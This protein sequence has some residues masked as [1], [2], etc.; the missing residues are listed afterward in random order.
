MLYNYNHKPLVCMQT[1]ST[2]YNETT[3]MT[4]KGVLWHSTGC[5]NPELRRYVQPSE[6]T[7]TEDSFSRALWLEILGKNVNGNDWNHINHRAGL[8]CWIG[9]LANGSITTVQTMPWNYAPWGCG[10]GI[11][12]SC[13]NG[14]IQFEICEPYSLSDRAY[15]NAVYKEACELTAYLC[16]MYNIDPLGIATHSSGIKVPTILCHKDSNDYG[17][18]GNHGDIMHW[19]P[20]HGKTMNDVRADVAALLRGA[21]FQLA[22][23]NGVI[24]NKPSTGSSGATLPETYTPTGLATQVVTI[25]P[26]EPI[27]INRAAITKTTV[28]SVSIE[29]D[30]SDNFKHYEWT[31]EIKTLKDNKKFLSNKFTVSKNKHSLTIDGLAPDR[32]YSVEFFAKNGSEELKKSS[33]IIFRTLKNKP[34]QVKNIT[35]EVDSN[36]LI[37]RIKC[38]ITVVEPAK[39]PAGYRVSLL[40]NGYEVGYSDSLIEPTKNELTIKNIYLEDILMELDLNIK[41]LKQNDIIQLGINAWIKDDKTYVFAEATPKCSNSIYLRP[42]LQQVDKAHVKVENNFKH[43]ILM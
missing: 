42:Y 35:F 2:C 26:V 40:V 22:P 12:G 29:L 10:P 28:T 36:T 34:N 6:R 15:F 38:T 24:T 33:A 23:E 8:N 4:V 3:T 16:K 14:W 41:E 19:F 1:Q 32:A 30:L 5:G 20:L 9:Q 11:Y 25:K 18:G 43:A 31:Y 27:L 7:P 39:Q 21:N 13:N 37:D 17:L